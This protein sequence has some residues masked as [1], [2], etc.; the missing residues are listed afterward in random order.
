MSV[1]LL[2]QNINGGASHDITTLVKELT[3]TTKRA[4]APGTLDVTIISDPQ[5]KI[6]HGGI[7]AL[8]NGDKGLIYGY[9]FKYSCNNKDEIQITAYDQLRYLKNKD[10]YVFKGRRADQ[11]VATIAADFKIK[12]GK[13]ANTGYVIPKMVMDSKDL[14]DIILHALDHT[15]IHSKQMFYLWDDYGLLRISN[16]KDHHISLTLGDG[17]LVTDYDYES[18]IDSDT[19][20]RIKLV[21]DNKKTGKRDVYIVENTNNQKRWGILQHYDKVDENLNKA[22]IEAQA[23]NLLALKNRPTRTLTIEAIADLTV[24]AG[25]SVF[26]K[27]KDIGISGWYVIDECEH[28]LIDEKMSLKLVVM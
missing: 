23:E 11:V 7:L 5:V 22:Q 28:N 3:W 25:R 24:R 19:A 15:L 6:D 27:I 21:R 26:V 9:V 4:G 14:F 17:S 13:L 10:T 1:Q 16:V 20:N 18:D 12:T 2:Y 8:K